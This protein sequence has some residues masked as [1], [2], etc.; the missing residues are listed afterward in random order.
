MPKSKSFLTTNG[1]RAL[2]PLHDGLHN[3]SHKAY[4]FL[5]YFNTGLEPSPPSPFWGYLVDLAILGS[6]F[7]VVR[8]TYESDEGF[9]AFPWHGNITW[10]QN[11]YFYLLLAISICANLCAFWCGYS[12]VLNPKTNWSRAEWINMAYYFYGT[13]GNQAKE[14]ASSTG[15]YIGMLGFVLKKTHG[16]TKGSTPKTTSIGI[17]WRCILQIRKQ[18]R[19]SGSTT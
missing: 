4:R 19:Y 15:F 11:R 14:W 6:Y 2:L 10:S 1:P 9:W 13:T 12:E 5:P 7:L 18:K 17:S 16:T 8:L 3:G